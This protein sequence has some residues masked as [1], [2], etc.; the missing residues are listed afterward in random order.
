MTESQ[1]THYEELVARM[2]DCGT[3]VES[4]EQRLSRQEIETPSWGYGDSGTRFNVFGQEGV[5]RDPSERLEDAARVHAHT[6]ICPSVAIH[7]PWDRVE[8]YSAL[9]DRANSLGLRLGAVNPNLFQEDA[10]RLGSVTHP[11]ATVRRQATDQI[12]ECVEIAR[13]IDSGLL[14]LWLPDGTNYAGQ[15]SFIGRRHRMLECLSITPTWQTG[16]RRLPSARGSGSG[17]RCSWTS[18]T[19]HRAST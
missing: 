19:T 7:I 10:Y 11:D 16:A 8:D 14:S 6:G 12:L 17:P 2:E 13:E 3:D 1:Q 15:D 18:G 4:I 5:P 9:K